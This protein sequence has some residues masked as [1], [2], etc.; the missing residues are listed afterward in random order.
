MN[1]ISLQATD[2]DPMKA[3]KVNSEALSSYSAMAYIYV[4]SQQVIF[5]ISEFDKQLPE[6][7]RVL[8]NITECGL[9]L[10]AFVFLASTQKWSDFKDP[11]LRI[12][13]ARTQKN[14]AK[15]SKSCDRFLNVSLHLSSFRD[16]RLDALYVCLS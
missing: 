1:N 10:E 4:L 3:A 6:G 13:D 16:V 8:I 15:A 14:Y 2:G 12:R 5:F 7:L 11:R 9:D